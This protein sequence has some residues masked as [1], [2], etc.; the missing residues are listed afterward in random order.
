MLSVSL[1]VL[2]VDSVSVISGLSAFFKM[3]FVHDFR[4]ELKELQVSINVKGMIK[5][6]EWS[7]KSLNTIQMGKFGAVWMV[8]MTDKLM[9]VGSCIDCV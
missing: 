4:I 9:E 1:V 8:N 2:L 7:F 6:S 3:S 5:L